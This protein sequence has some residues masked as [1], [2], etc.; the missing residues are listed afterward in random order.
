MG[1]RHADI[2]AELNALAERVIGAAIAVH[3]ELGPGFL[4][5]SYEAALLYELELRGLSASQQVEVGVQ[6]KG[7]ALPAQRL[8][9]VVEG[10]IVLELKAVE[11]V[12]DVYL[13]QLVSYL[14]AGGFA[15]GIL[16]NFNVPVLKDGIFRRLNNKHP[17]ISAPPRSLRASAF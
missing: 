13:A 7:I 3:R 17:L 4:E 2:P 5:R 11:S 12:S 15:L 10:K 16:L 14:R 1:M 8:D 6:Y 9:L